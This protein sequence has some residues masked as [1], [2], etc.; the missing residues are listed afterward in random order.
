MNITVLI[1]NNSAHLSTADKVLS[2]GECRGFVK[3]RLHGVCLSL[4]FFSLSPA[5]AAG[6]QNILTFKVLS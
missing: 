2:G 4:S 1:I 5:A 3:D 6:P